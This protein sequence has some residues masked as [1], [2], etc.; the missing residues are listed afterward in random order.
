[1]KLF[2][3]IP[4][5]VHAALEIVAAPVLMVAPLLSGASPVVGVVSFVIGALLLGLA[6][7]TLGERAVV[8]LSVHPAFDNVLAAATVLAGALAVAT[9]D[10][11]VAAFLV[12]FGTAHLALTAST[13]FS[14]PAG[15]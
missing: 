11:V 5:N 2:R 4:L 13:R 8:P 1:M 14:V 6:V 9:G 10:G 3:A 12:G 15:A 7:S